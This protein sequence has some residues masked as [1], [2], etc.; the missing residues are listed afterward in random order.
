MPRLPN[1]M[2]AILGNQTVPGPKLLD[3]EITNTFPLIKLERQSRLLRPNQPPEDIGAFDHVTIP[4][5]LRL[6]LSSPKEHLFFNA[7]P[8]WS[9]LENPS[10]K[11][12]HYFTF[13]GLP[14][15]KTQPLVKP[16]ET[17]TWHQ[18]M[19]VLPFPDK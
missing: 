13:I 8:V 10:T 15:A 19:L 18:A 11:P 12:F 1:G 6:H 5:D 3:I 9:F 16:N 2:I 4:P 7:E 17:K 14:F